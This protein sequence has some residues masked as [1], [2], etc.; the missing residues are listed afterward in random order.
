MR[1]PRDRKTQG[2]PQIVDA[3]K[4]KVHSVAN[5]CADSRAG[6]TQEVCQPMPAKELP[7]NAELFAY[8]WL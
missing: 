4:G 1:S 2:P 8:V 6:W 3:K 7:E 5:H